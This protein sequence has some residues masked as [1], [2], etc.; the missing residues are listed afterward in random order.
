MDT[1]VVGTY[2]WAVRM[3][4]LSRRLFVSYFVVY[5]VGPDGHRQNHLKA[6]PHDELDQGLL[7]GK[8]C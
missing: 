4:M 8:Q 1:L 3:K 6:W 2:P 7:T 5:G